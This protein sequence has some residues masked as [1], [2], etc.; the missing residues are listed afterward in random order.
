MIPHT[1][2]FIDVVLQ[3]N[4][5][6]EWVVGLYTY[7]LTVDQIVY[8]TAELQI[9]VLVYQQSRVGQTHH[10]CTMISMTRSIDIQNCFPGSTGGRL[11]ILNHILTPIVPLAGC[12]A[13]LPGL[14]YLLI[15]IIIIILFS[16]SVGSCQQ[17]RSTIQYSRS[18]ESLQDFY[19]QS[20]NAPN[21]I[22]KCVKSMTGMGFG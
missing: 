4:L 8:I 21:T 18:Q 9:N 14:Y 15:I 1:N 2:V 10:I 16:V 3:L 5:F 6:K 19:F 17:C 20:S 12:V 7:K 13:Q 22:A 11:H